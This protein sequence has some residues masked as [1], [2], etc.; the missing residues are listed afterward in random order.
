MC[1]V[2]DADDRILGVITDGDLRRHVDELNDIRTLPAGRVM[3]RDPRTITTGELAAK[4]V[5]VMQK[6]RVQGLLV[7]DRD[8]RLVGALNFQDLLQAGVV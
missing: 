5:D 6:H 1:A 4:A 7:V 2:V 8:R 3:T